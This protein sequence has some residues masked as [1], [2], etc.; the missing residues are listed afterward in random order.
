MS[1]EIASLPIHVSMGDP[2]NLGQCTVS[3][4]VTAQ[5]HTHRGQITA[6]DMV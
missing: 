3:S 1:Q 5:S 2:V 4:G 6:R